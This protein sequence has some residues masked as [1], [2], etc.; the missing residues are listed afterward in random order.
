MGRG[1]VHNE[2]SDGEREEEGGVLLGRE[3]GGGGA[4]NCSG[5][6][7]NIWDQ[8]SLLASSFC[9]H[10]LGNTIGAEKWRK[11]KGKDQAMRILGI[12]S[13][14]NEAEGAKPVDTSKSQFVHQ[15]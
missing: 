4:C 1:A 15:Q 6:D 3:G 7:V 10:R 14:V 9:S 11:V 12:G 13:N 2:E 8:V 5:K